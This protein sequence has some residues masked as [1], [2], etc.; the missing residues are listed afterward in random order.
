MACSGFNQTERVLTFRE[1]SV[2]TITRIEI[3]RNDFKK[4]FKMYF[5]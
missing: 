3:V 2:D 1:I 4:Y 5:K